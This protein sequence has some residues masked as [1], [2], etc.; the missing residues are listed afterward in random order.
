M[1]PPFS[2]GDGEVSGFLVGYNLIS[3]SAVA[4]VLAA[5]EAAMTTPTAATARAA[6]PTA[7]TAT[8]IAPTAA[9]TDVV[10]IYYLGKDS[11]KYPGQL[12]VKTSL[13]L[14]ASHP[15][16]GVNLPGFENAAGCK[17]RSKWADY[18]FVEGNPPMLLKEWGKQ[19]ELDFRAK[20]V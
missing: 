1:Q 10:E 19:Y 7:T 4:V 6:R 12:Q 17:H 13:V 15:L 16:V 14:C 2:F 18:V 20:K 8:A 11:L 3:P 9:V 5:K